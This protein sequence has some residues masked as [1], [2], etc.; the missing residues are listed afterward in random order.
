MSKVEIFNFEH[1]GFVIPINYYD[2]QTNKIKTEVCHLTGDDLLNGYNGHY[3]EHEFIFALGQEV[4]FTDLIALKVGESLT[5]Q[6][7]RD[8][9]AFGTMTIF[10]TK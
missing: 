3:N 7:N 9:P 2:V 4:D 8:I 10:R 1:L 6:E 5:F